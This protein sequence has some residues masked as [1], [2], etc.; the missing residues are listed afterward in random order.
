MHGLQVH[1][2]DHHTDF[3]LILLKK[4]LPKRPDLRV[5]LMSA[6][7]DAALFSEYFGGCP[8]VNI[9]GFTYPVQASNTH[10][11]LILTLYISCAGKQHPPLPDFGK[12]R[13]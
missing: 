9:P 4:L 8:V 13:I 1:E 3:A 10:P 11:S 6:T 7:L 12:H 5:I 2:R